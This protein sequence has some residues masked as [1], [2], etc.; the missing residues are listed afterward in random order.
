MKIQVD[1]R[2]EHID[3]GIKE[4]SRS[5]AIAL[6]L[7]DKNYTQVI[8]ED[9]CTFVYEDTTWFASLPD[10][11]LEFIE[12]FDNGNT[13]E[14]ISFEILACTEEERYADDCK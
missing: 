11:A 4:D 12:T 7:R 14:P 10:E 5:C 1:V 3:R 6:A 13:V 2:Q 9:E 8:V